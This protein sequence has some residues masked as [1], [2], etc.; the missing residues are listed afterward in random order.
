V[1]QHTWLQSGSIRNNILFNLPFDKERYNQVVKS[2]ELY[3][4]FEFFVDGDLTEIGEQG[5][6]LSGG[7]R[8]RIALAR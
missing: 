7:Q 3:K 8:Q 5:E 4:D 1:A 2:C 6:T